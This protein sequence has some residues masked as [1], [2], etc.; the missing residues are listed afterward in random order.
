MKK[1]DLYKLS[2]FYTLTLLLIML[3][4]MVIALAQNSRYAVVVSISGHMSNINPGTAECIIDA[5]RYAE[6]RNVPLIMV[7][8]T[9][10]GWLDSAFRIA[11]AILKAR[12]PVIGFVYGGK[13]LSA[14]TLILLPTHIAAMTPWSI[15]GAMQPVQYDPFTGRVVYVNE[16]K[17]IN[18]IIEKVRLYADSRGRNVTVAERF[19]RENL[20]LSAEEAIKYHVVDLIASSLDELISKVNGRV[21]KLYGNVTYRIDIRGY[22]TYSCSLRSQLTS[23]L[24]DP[25][26]S[27]ILTSIGMFILI[28][29]LVSGHIVIAPLGVALL[30]LG[31][32][33]SGFN[34]NIAAIL[35]IILG[36]TLLAVEFLVLPGFGIVG[37]SGIIMLIFGV[38]LLPMVGPTTIANPEEYFSKLRS[39]AIAVGL[40]LGGFTAF[41]VYKVVRVRRAKP[42]IFTLEGKVGRAADRIEPGK[43]GYVVVEGEYWKATSDEH[44]EPGDEVAVISVKN[45]MTLVVKRHRYR[46]EVSKG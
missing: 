28:L 3:L 35:L 8:D 16:S 40:G 22:I 42:K 41:T 2:I 6:E 18:P 37:I 23:L 19:V 17:I 14:G 43:Y 25:L 33:G 39:F 29:S 45:D 31:L 11:D 30:I 36:T 32:I 27:G 21:V 24:S 20:V 15:I 44:I 5:I 9:Y 7:L 38:T 1:R 46:S 26:L 34:V 13:A 12:V 10:G 4:G